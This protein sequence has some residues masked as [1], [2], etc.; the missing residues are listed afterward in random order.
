MYTQFYVFLIY[1]SSVFTRELPTYLKDKRCSFKEDLEACFVKNGNL[2]IPLLAK[3]DPDFHI[4]KMNPME[5]SFIQLIST[6]TLGLNLTNVEIHGLDQARIERAKLNWKDNIFT[7]Y[8]KSGNLTIEGDYVADGKVL[9]MP[10]KGNGRFKVFLKNGDFEAANIAEMLEIKGEKFFKLTDTRLNYKFER[11]EFQFDN[12]FDG[13]KELG[14]Q[15][16]KFLNENW[17][18]LLT[19]F[20]PGISATIS[21]IIRDIFMKL[22]TISVKSAF[23]DY[24]S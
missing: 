13:N 23:K 21:S 8:L 11:V 4:P 24:D 10:I 19:D 18:I 15:V 1:L 16:N 17:D 20:G 12:L 22:S 14:D 9:V 3:G 5:I 6:P 7:I 2:A